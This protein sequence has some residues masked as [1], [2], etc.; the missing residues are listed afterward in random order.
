MPTKKSKK[1]KQTKKTQSTNN[2]KKQGA[3]KRTKPSDNPP[4]SPP[5]PEKVGK[6]P[7]RSE[8]PSTKPPAKRKAGRPPQDDRAITPAVLGQIGDMF[9]AGWKTS[10]IAV[11]V[12]VDWSTVDYHLK[13]TIQPIWEKNLVHKASIELAKI[14]RMEHIAWKKLIEDLPFEERVTVTESLLEGGGDL[15]LVKRIRSTNPRRGS[16]EWM[17]IIQ[18]C[19]QA[20]WKLLDYCVG[21]PKVKADDEGFRIAGRSTEQLDKDMV[22]L[23]LEKIDEQRKLQAENERLSRLNYP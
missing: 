10:Q 6:P 23:L 8:K 5:A 9:L 21:S 17:K 4:R 15:Q 3:D 1:R 22:Q 19:I 20:R 2:S 11:K 12:G 16:T 7:K 13:S 14:D 18:W